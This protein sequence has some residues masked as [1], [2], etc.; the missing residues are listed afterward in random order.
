[1]SFIAI[2][3]IYLFTGLSPF[4]LFIISYTLSPTH[5]LPPTLHIVYFISYPS[6]LIITV[7]I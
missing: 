1:L 7:M 5:L 6:I 4:T 3:F 2:I